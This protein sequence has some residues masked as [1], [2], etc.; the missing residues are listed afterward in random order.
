[1]FLLVRSLS[2]DA[3]FTTSHSSKW[4]YLS[5][6]PLRVQIPLLYELRCVDIEGKVERSGHFRR[7]AD[8][9]FATVQG[10]VPD[11]PA[12]DMANADLF[13]LI[14]VVGKGLDPVTFLVLL[15][16]V[17]PV[18]IVRGIVRDEIRDG[19]SALLPI[20]QFLLLSLVLINLQRREHRQH[21]LTGAILAFRHVLL[22]L[23]FVF[24]S[25]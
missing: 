8:A 2:W 13:R 17:I 16:N 5:Q 9:D 4:T 14:V 7:E 20:D 22:F 19:D 21:V 6:A 3:S 23:S 25:Q 15:F 11:D 1:V 24:L 12:A 10:R 18:R